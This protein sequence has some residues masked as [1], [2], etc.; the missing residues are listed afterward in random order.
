VK[1]A[2]GAILA[3]S[4]I[5]DLLFFT[6]FI[7]S[8]DVLYTT[9]ARRMAETGTL[10]PDPAAHEARLLMIGWCA[11][12]GVWVRHDV[13]AVAASFIFF[14]QLLNLLTFALA[15]PLAGTAAGLLAAA[16]S[17]AF[18]LLVVFS[19]TILPDIPMAACLVAAFLVFRSAYVHGPGR[20]R[21]GL[22]LTLSGALVG[23]AY[24]AK[25]SGLVPVPFFLALGFTYE[26]RTP[27]S[28]GRTSR[29]LT[30]AAAF[31]GGL[32]LVAG[33]EALALRGLTGSW[34][35][36]MGSFLEGGGGGGGPL[37]AALGQRAALLARTLGAHA[38]PGAAVLV[39]L[40]AALYAAKR[41]G[42]R[43]T[44]LF[45]AWYAAYYTWG[46][47][48]LGSYSSPSL[49]LRY[50]IPCIP[51]LLVPVSAALC[52]AYVWAGTQAG[53]L[54]PRAQPAMRAAAA[55]LSTAAVVALLGVCDR[56]AGDLYGAPLVTQSL[57][58]LRAS[59]S[60]GPMPL[61]ISETLGAQLFPLLLERP[62]G[63]LF[64]HEVGPAQLER[65]RRE[66]GFRFLDLSPTSPLG[67]VELNP[68]LGWRHGLPA[69]ERRVERLVESLLVG[70]ATDDGWIMRP[71]GRFDRVGPRSAEL[72]ALFGDAAA[73]PGLRHRPDR[74][75]VVY[76]L[77]AAD[78][79][80][81]YPLSPLFPGE[82]P[83]V[84]NGMFQDWSE[85]GPVGWQSRDARAS[86]ARGPEGG[87]AVRIGPGTLSY[88]WQSLR[89][90][91][92]VAGRRL[93]LRARVRSDARNAARLWIKI[94][95][96]T[97]WEEVFGEPHPGD[98]TWRELEAALPVP[99]GFGGAEARV[100]LL[101]A[102][103][104]GHSEFGDVQLSA[105]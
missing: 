53:R 78:Q 11:L 60:S 42:L 65:W 102:G 15:R 31:L 54:H 13:Q 72:R 40:I 3:A 89:A 35:F 29:A 7:A 103:T 83:S 63:L 51:F 27:E 44:L 34:S 45:P 43:P 9:A 84:V 94:A 90:P 77:T 79:D 68:L 80:F 98:A 88:L 70:P 105:R 17:A 75:L 10:W 50:F 76:Q 91:A 71:A 96:G 33:L 95:F 23:L 26:R 62:Q 97:E 32:G 58:A 61:V 16:L 18:P 57:R 39:I 52:D 46:S 25:E 5:V 6:G 86:R 64:S 22:L 99:P 20:R 92:C 73:L 81:R 37:L 59:G 1:R 12:V 24:L 48:S 67:R 55:V 28:N 100:V 38:A 69:S 74:G 4:V 85:A 93:V 14:H 87:E 21:P 47:A 101:H 36:R 8:D 49:Q 66:G 41:P 82:G 30:R 56:Q 19:T 2:L 104:Q